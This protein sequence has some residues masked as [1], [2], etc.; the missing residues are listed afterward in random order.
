M[1]TVII[2]LTNAYMEMAC[3]DPWLPEAKRHWIYRRTV[4]YSG[5]CLQ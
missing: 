5:I 2:L 4:D 1:H 3:Y